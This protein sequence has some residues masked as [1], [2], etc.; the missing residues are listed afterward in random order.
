MS[1]QALYPALFLILS[2]GCLVKAEAPDAA[3]V[4]ADSSDVTPDTRICPEPKKASC[5]ENKESSGICDPVCQTGKC[6]WCN[7]KCS[8]DKN[9]EVFCSPIPP[10]DKGALA[11]RNDQCFFTGNSITGIRWD[12]CE[13][14]LVCLGSSQTDDKPICFQPCRNPKYDC[15]AGQAEHDCSHRI[16]PLNNPGDLLVS[17]NVCNPYPTSTCGEISGEE[18]CDPSRIIAVGGSGSC[19]E[20]FVCR[21]V[22]IDSGKNNSRTTCDMGSGQTRFTNCN[23]NREC[24]PAFSCLKGFCR[25]ICDPKDPGLPCVNLSCVVKDYGS[26]YGYCL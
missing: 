14:G 7:E 13:P 23:S 22:G 6:D 4:R 20:G 17:V 10:I 1:R 18:C 26:Q 15:P 5:S 25:R 19:P 11:K 21:L 3:V 24:M 9:G 16:I 8:Y 2:A 12:N